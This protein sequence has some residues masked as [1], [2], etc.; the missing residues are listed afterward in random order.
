MFRPGRGSGPAVVQIN[1]VYFLMKIRIIQK[2]SKFPKT[3]IFDF[4]EKSQGKFDIQNKSSFDFGTFL[5]HIIS[6][7]STL[8]S[9]QK[10]LHLHVDISSFDIKYQQ[11]SPI[12]S[13]LSNIS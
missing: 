10:H 6:K 3:E 11:N 5:K 7:F 4:S 1:S 8:G 13:G 9:R 12:Q 2:I